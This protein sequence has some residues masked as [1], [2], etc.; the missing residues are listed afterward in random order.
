[1]I[2]KALGPAAPTNVAPRGVHRC[3]D[4]KCNRLQEMASTAS[5]YPIQRNQSIQREQKP[6][7]IPPITATDGSLKIHDT[8]VNVFEAAKPNFSVI[9]RRP[10]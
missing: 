3:E 5:A 2:G 4:L 1:M 7:E 10:A 8:G 6:E 9:F